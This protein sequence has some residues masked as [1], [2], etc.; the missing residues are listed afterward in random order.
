M[1][2]LLACS[3]LA[4]Q[5]S[6]PLPERLHAAPFLGQHAFGLLS[7]VEE[8]QAMLQ[9]GCRRVR[10]APLFGHLLD[11]RRDPLGGVRESELQ[12]LEW[13]QLLTPCL[14]LAVAGV[15]AKDGCHARRFDAH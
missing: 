5:A 14:G 7:R 13:Q 2:W 6:P 3:S 4:S 10:L 1:P 12:V 15:V 11:R 9:S 8:I